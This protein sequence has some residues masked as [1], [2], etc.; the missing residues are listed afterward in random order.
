MREL[1]LNGLNAFATLRRTI[2][3][4]FLYG[5]MGVLRSLS[6]DHIKSTYIR[7]DAASSMVCQL[8]ITKEVF[9]K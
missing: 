4:F 7:A 6:P 2:N 9:S 1:S 3:A 5:V 8:E